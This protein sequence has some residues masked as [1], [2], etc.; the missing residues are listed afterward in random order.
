MA[1][2]TVTPLLYWAHESPRLDDHT[3]PAH[4]STSAT[5]PPGERDVGG[6]IKPGPSQV[7]WVLLNSHSRTGP[8]I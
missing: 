5:W 7:L 4:A 1:Y 6:C 2:V 3:H 8:E